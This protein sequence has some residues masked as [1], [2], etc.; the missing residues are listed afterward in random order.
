AAC[1]AACT[2]WGYP[3]AG[4]EYGGQCWC[5][6]G[7]DLLQTSAACSMPCG[8]NPSQTCGGEWALSAWQ[9]DTLRPAYGPI[10]PVLAGF[11][12]VGCYKDSA[13][14]RAFRT[15]ARILPVAATEGPLNQHGCAA[16][17]LGRG[18]EVSGTEYGSECWCGDQ[19]VF[20]SS[21]QKIAESECGAPCAAAQE[22]VCGGT[23]AATVF[24][25]SY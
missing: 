7:M 20:V 6:S 1:T 2:R 14:A 9:A 8:T 10:N 18:Y 23:W 12:Y 4:T 3:V 15:K 17:C 5:G 21:A 13:A 19:D 16:H 24:V 25:A 22:E 11:A